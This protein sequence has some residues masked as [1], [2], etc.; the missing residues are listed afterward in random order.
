MLTLEKISL[1][2]TSRSSFSL[3]KIIAT[4]F[5]IIL[6]RIFIENFSS[7]SGDGYFFSWQGVFIHATL[8]FFSV[9]LSLAIITY[10]FTKEPFEEILTY[11]TKT[12]LFILVV[13]IVDIIFEG[14]VALNYITVGPGKLV[15]YYFKVMNPLS[16]LGITI[17]QHAAAYGIFISLGYFVYK[18]N[19]S[20]TKGIL[21]AL[22][23][24]TMLFFCAIIPSLLVA[25]SNYAQ[26]SGQTVADTYN[27][28]LNQSWFS[29][30]LVNTSLFDK[31]IFQSETIHEISMGR[32]YFI[33]IIIQIAIIFF[34]SNKKLWLAL[35]NDLRI[36]RI[37]Y[38]FI[39]ASIGIIINQRIF[40]SVNLQNPINMVALVVFFSLI[41]L[42]IWLAAFINDTEDVKIDSISNPSRPLVTKLISDHDWNLMQII[43]IVLIF[44]GTA[45]LNESTAF[46]L[47]LA[48]ASYYIYSAQPLRLKRHFI[49]SSI[50]TGLAAVAIAMAGFFL[51]SP[52]QHIAAFPLK[53]VLIIGIAYGLFSNLKD[54]KD[55]AGDNYENMRTIPVVFGLL[56]SKYIISCLC[57]LVLI[58]VPIILHVNSMILFSVSVSIFLFYLFTKKEYQEKYIFLA[59]FLY[60]ITFFLVTM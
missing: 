23:G 12:Y 55:F 49:F 45:S 25:I 5:S 24:Y 26:T 39:I 42:N 41:T 43:L 15:P 50:L 2:E 46:L 9:F 57:S 10:F 17:G 35:K 20:I 48:Q 6:V 11:L 31:I 40:G 33:F 16:G 7:P 8:Y 59:F 1:K 21:L 47:M 34:I 54:I 56:N 30:Y 18:K 3:L 29:N 58:S 38:W 32:I 22:A 53:A 44:F 27:L 36:E 14:K 60:M 51:V 4:V 19:N 28:I 37:A 52:D 13:P